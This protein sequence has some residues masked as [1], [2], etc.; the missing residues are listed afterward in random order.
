MYFLSGKEISL[1]VP[2][3]QIKTLRLGDPSFTFQQYDDGD[4]SNSN[5]LEN[6]TPTSKKRKYTSSNSSQEEEVILNP[7]YLTYKNK[8]QTKQ[9]LNKTKNLTF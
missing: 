5:S 8:T 7:G 4:N 9:L 2:E 3:Q 1:E 6:K